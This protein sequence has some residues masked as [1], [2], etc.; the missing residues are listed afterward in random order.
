METFFDLFGTVVRQ[1]L[2][3]VVVLWVVAGQLAYFALWLPYQRRR[4]WVEATVSVTEAVPVGR[5]MRGAEAHG[6]G[7]YQLRGT[8]HTPQGP[9]EAGSVEQVKA[10]RAGVVGQTVPC[11]YDPDRPGLMTLV[12]RSAPILGSGPGVVVLLIVAALVVVPAVVA[13]RDWGAL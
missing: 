6:Q 3:W 13:L 10:D 2:V 9:V 1:P 8:L 11:R 12:P 5:T 4:S 7:L